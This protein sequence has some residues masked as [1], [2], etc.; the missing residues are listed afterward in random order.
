MG[1]AR[2]TKSGIPLPAF[3]I[4]G[5]VIGAAVVLGVL[6]P[7]V[8]VTVQRRALATARDRHPP[9][10]RLVDVGGHW[11]HI[12]CDGPSGPKTPRI[13]IDAG[14]ASFSLDWIDIQRE[15]ARSYRVCTYDRAGYGWS[16]PGPLPRNAHQVV[17]ELHALLQESGE[18]GPYLMVGH[19]LGGLHVQLYA[20][21]YPEEVAGL[22]LIDSA[23]PYGLSPGFER[24]Q[25][26]TL[27][28]YRTMRQLTA[29]GL[30]R[31]LGPLGGKEAVPPSVRGLP[32]DVQDAYL[33]LLLDPVYYETASAEMVALP[34]SVE[35]TDAALYGDPPLGDTPLIVLTAARS[36]PPGSSP[37][38]EETVSA[39]PEQVRAQG[40]L[41][42]LSTR[43]ERWMLGQSG[44]LVH[45]D[46]PESILEAVEVV[47]DMVQRGR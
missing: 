24:Q 28:F 44:H 35:Q 37:Y 42:Q 9:P 32:E 41:A 33:A 25:R 10:G 11:L 18:A 15:L 21:L 36:A 23:T 7:L 27:G 19:S 38:T 17:Q 39:D 31:V 20:A 34:E 26:T 1:H 16:Q 46:A 13:V 40:E 14:N 4:I 45:L 2:E 12:Y 29:A 22:V 8:L 43:G 47:S 6:V 3:R 5:T 30:L